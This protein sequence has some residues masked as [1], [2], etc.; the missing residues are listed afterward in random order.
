MGLLGLDDGLPPKPKG[1]HWR[2]YRRLEQLD[3]RL[4]DSWCGGMAASQKCAQT[5][6]ANFPTRFGQQA[7]DGPPGV[8]SPF[9]SALF[10]SL[11]TNPTIY[12]HAGRGSHQNG[13]AHRPLVFDEASD[14]S[15][16]EGIHRALS[17]NCRATTG[18]QPLE[19]SRVHFPPR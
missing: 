10:A 14:G 16:S 13:R 1:M 2:T 15:D 19:T 7:L 11:D 6:L 18:I 3:E 17:L 5:T 12:R 9:A 4:A 8:Q